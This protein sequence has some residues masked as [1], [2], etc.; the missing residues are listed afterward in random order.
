MFRPRQSFFNLAL[1]SVGVYFRANV[2]SVTYFP[3]TKL[4]SSQVFEPRRS[5]IAILSYVFVDLCFHGTTFN[6][7]L[8]NFPWKGLGLKSFGKFR[9]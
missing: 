8:Q 7:A 1:F 3:Q 5:P 4:R 6:I 9:Y 2:T